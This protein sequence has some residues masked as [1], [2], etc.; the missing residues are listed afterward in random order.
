MKLSLKTLLATL[1]IATGTLPLAAHAAKNNNKSLWQDTPCGRPDESPQCVIK[2]FWSCRSGW[3]PACRLAGLEMPIDTEENNFG[4]DVTAVQK[5][6]WVH[7]WAEIFAAIGGETDF[8]AQLGPLPAGRNRFLG[9]RKLSFKQFPVMEM[10]YQAYDIDNW[11]CRRPKHQKQ[12][13]SEI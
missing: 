2:T 1:A 13:S 3:M 6:P 4:P 9:V 12:S 5:T 8:V 10:A 7:S 11:R